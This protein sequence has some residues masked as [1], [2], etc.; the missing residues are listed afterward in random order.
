[1]GYFTL[2]Q[3]IGRGVVRPS[4]HIPYRKGYQT[5]HLYTHSLPL[6]LFE[7]VSVMR[8]PGLK[9]ASDFNHFKAKIFILN[10]F[11]KFVHKLTQRTL[12]TL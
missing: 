5:I 9:K 8:M 1:M 11:Q 2:Q 4:T 10:I 12:F 3:H 6:N 7:K